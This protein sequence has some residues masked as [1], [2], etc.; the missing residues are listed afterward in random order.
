ML[1]VYDQ[2]LGT[3]VTA[4]LVEETD[5]FKAAEL[6]VYARL[7]GY[8][9]AFNRI[10]VPY[11]VDQVVLPAVPAISSSVS[12]HD[13]E[14]PLADR[15]SAVMSALQ[16]TTLWPRGVRPSPPRKG[17]HDRVVTRDRWRATLLCAPTSP[18][19]GD[20]ADAA[21]VADSW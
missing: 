10:A 11:Y 17:S 16:T 19:S 12:S 9:E 1:K 2:A 3:F 15:G 20:H 6:E 8:W 14:E 5:F 13:T 7:E 18:H 4:K 21:A